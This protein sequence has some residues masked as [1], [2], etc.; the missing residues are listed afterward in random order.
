MTKQCAR[1][2]M[3]VR[4]RRI[5]RYLIVAL[6]AM[7]FAT[8]FPGRCAAQQVSY[9]DF[10]GPAAASPG[11]TSTSC[12]PNSAASGVL[13]CFNS[14]GAG[15]SFI[16]DNSY[17]ISI[18]PNASNGS[19]YALQLTQSAA[20][21]DSSVW[22]ST[23]QNVANGFTVW[24]AFK[25][26]T[27]G[28]AP[29]TGDGLAFVIQNAKGNGS[30]PLGNCAESGSGL[31][32]L[33]PG[34]GCMGYGGIDNSIALEA[35]TFADG[36]DP[37]DF[38]E[39]YYNDNHIALQGCGPGLANSPAHYSS[40]LVSPLV[41]TSCL[42]AL[43]GQN[44]IASNPA[45]SSTAGAVEVDDGNPHQVVIVYNGPNDSPSNYLYV[46]LDPVFNPG[47]HTPVAGST[48][49]FSGPFDIT[50][51]INVN[52][53]TAY[54]GFTAATGFG[55]EQ[56]ELMGF[57]FAPHGYGDANVCPMGQST[58][59]PCSNTLAVPFSF[60][61]STAIGSVQV[62]TQGATGL[63]FQPGSG[64]TCA[65]S[66]TSCTVNVTFAP[67][68]PGLRLGAVELLDGSG[69]RLATKMIYGIGQGPAIAFS[70]GTQTPV[71]SANSP[72]A[73]SGVAVDAAGDTFIAENQGTQ[74]N[75]GLVVKVAANGTQTLV[76]SGLEYPQGLAVDGAGDLFI[77]DNNLNAVVEVTPAG[78]QT[79]MSFGLTA[80]LGVAVD[81]AGD[82]FVSD[83]NAG[84]VA[85]APAGC[86]TSACATP[87]YS[88]GPGLH[89]VGLAVDGAGD[90][91]IADFADTAPGKVVEIPAG[92][93]SSSC[94]TTVG[95]GWDEPEALA[96]DAAGDVFVADEASKVVEV[97]AGCTNSAC[98]ITISGILAYGVAVDAKGDVFI[99]DL[100][101][102]VS[103]DPNSDQVIVVNGSQA[104]SLSYLSTTVGSTSSD[105][106]HSL[107][108]Q[109]IGNQTL[110]AVSPGLVVG[111]N[112]VQAIGSGTPADCTTSF[113]LLPGAGCDLSISFEPQSAGNPLTSTAVL[114]DNALN[115]APATQ[116]VALSGVGLAANYTLSVSGVGSGTGTV[117]ATP[118]PISCSL[119]SGAGTGT[120]QGSYQPGVP[121]T[122]TASATGNSIFLGWGGAC[123]SSG[124]NATCNLTIS[125]GT[126]AA[127]VTANFAPTYTLS[128]TALG[129]GVGT[130]TSTPGPI[131]CSVNNGVGSGTCLGSYPSGSTVALTATASP[132]FVFNG[133]SGTCTPAG[134]NPVCN[135]VVGPA[136]NVI[137]DFVPQNFGNVNVC[138]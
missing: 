104:P 102:N 34:G 70:P 1:S 124:T 62:V 84:E 16:Q 15:L 114:T 10:N 131:S 103:S 106:P 45:S 90:L 92:C 22:Y 61:S 8:L 79:E 14:V 107:T 82:L 63:D 101:T 122:L 36:Y 25:I 138:P 21:Q 69:N 99:P 18:D 77:A 55:Y 54:L 117:I 87:V 17:T 56:H 126:G 37:W 52:N 66:V 58:P 93:T 86:T 60:A 65:G 116:S 20:S 119:A 130:V 49:L 24:Y 12:S 137:A 81:G 39:Y 7:I 111:Q 30:D 4:F 108:I 46:Y 6:C 72:Y 40:N 75:N 43:N 83:F 78:V 94:Q 68:A 120:C 2:A 95:S 9:Y 89:P 96:V 57:S 48:P 73:V 105:S 3:T 136:S 132:N 53:G 128:V 42:V 71:Y 13:F 44:T 91:F 11:Q 35:D 88:A 76:G 51:Y 19:A 47:T 135:V 64:S 41:P 109:N 33:G 100:N 26:T 98:Q 112:F 118:G 134:T 123:A 27:S 50:K 28:M 113:S 5:Q 67:K 127:S 121:V 133:W 32:A 29:N 125:T 23:P 74:S 115:A 59:A 129:T 85:E 31:T 97:P 110:D 80:Q 38:G